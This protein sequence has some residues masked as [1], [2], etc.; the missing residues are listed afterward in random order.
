M[1]TCLKYEVCKKANRGIEP[2]CEG[3][4]HYTPR[5]GTNDTKDLQLKNDLSA[6]N[7]SLFSQL[8]RLKDID[9]TTDQG[10]GELVRA[11]AVC[12]VSTQI[13]NNAALALKAHMTLNSGMIKSA[14]KMLGG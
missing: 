4:P 6:L 2:V 11:Q 10:K 12:G 1:N 9:P 8:D 14:P 7:D 5:P 3:C 13:I